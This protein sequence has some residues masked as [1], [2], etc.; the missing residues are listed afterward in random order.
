[1]LQG[2]AAADLLDLWYV[3]TN[4]PNGRR[5]ACVMLL[6][7]MTSGRHHWA[8][9]IDQS[10]C[11][12]NIMPESCISSV[13]VTV[14]ASSFLTCTVLRTAHTPSQPKIADDGMS[15]ATCLHMDRATNGNQWMN[16]ML[17]LAGLALCWLVVAQHKQL[18]LLLSRGI[19]QEGRSRLRCKQAASA[20]KRS[21]SVVAMAW[22]GC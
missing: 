2:T 13:Q 9:E 14:C 22:L 11:H 21:N 15:N 20:P 1:M 10:R 3:W 4:L 18:V 8:A 6:L 12:T 17:A 16:S 7:P 5:E 19:R